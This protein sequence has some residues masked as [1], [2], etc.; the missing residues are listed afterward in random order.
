MFLQVLVADII[1]IVHLLWIIFMLWGFMLTLWGF[2][3]KDFFDMWLFR[4]VHLFGITYVSFLFVMSKYCPLT[5]WE[6]CLRSKYD[7]GLIYAGSFMIN[8][9]KRLVYPDINPL[10]IQIPT[11]FIAVFTVVVFIIRPPKRIR[12]IFKIKRF[13]IK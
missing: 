12:Q 2:S 8:Y 10:I 9:A 11:I 1:V 6:N 13:T 3:R 5:L 7:P 4:T